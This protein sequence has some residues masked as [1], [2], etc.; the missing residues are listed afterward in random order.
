MAVGTHARIDIPLLCH[1]DYI[2]YTAVKHGLTLEVEV[3]GKKLGS[4]IIEH[5]FEE[6]KGKHSGL[7]GEYTG[8]NGALRALK[9]ALA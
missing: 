3:K 4:R 5:L 2:A 8:S 1:R 7:S 6:R 9:V